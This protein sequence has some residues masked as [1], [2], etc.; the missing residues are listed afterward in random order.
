MRIP[1]LSLQ[2]D[3]CNQAIPRKE[4]NGT[5]TSDKAG[6]VLSYGPS[7]ALILVTVDFSE[8]FVVG[9]ETDQLVSV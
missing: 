2:V 4:T 3:N 7:I 6:T 5:R 8:K 1:S 9:I